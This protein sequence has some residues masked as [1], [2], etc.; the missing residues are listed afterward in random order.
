MRKDRHQEVDLQNGM[1]GHAL[2]T[3]APHG[4]STKRKMQVKLVNA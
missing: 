2:I 1:Y 4:I 3:G